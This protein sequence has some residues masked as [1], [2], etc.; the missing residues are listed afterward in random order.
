MGTGWRAVVW[1]AVLAS[2]VIPNQLSAQQTQLG[3]II[4]NVRVSRGDFPA[5]PVLN[6]LEMRGTPIG[7]AYCDDQG[8]FGFYS[9]VANQYRVSVDD[10]GYEPVSETTNVDPATSQTKFVQI[11]LV[12]RA[13]A[14]TDPLPGR[15]VGHKPLP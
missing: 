9:L 6:S 14:K 8:R 12:P 10:D 7:S 1:S 4:G 15:G 3:R 11:T 5:H 13:N 2:F